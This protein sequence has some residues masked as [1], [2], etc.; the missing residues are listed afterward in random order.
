MTVWKQLG[1]V[2]RNTFN[3]DR[4]ESDLEEE[5]RAYVDL[6][7]AE[8]IQ[9][10]MSPEL[11]QR[12]ALMEVGSM[13]SVKEQVREVSAGWTLNVLWLDVHHALRAM[14]RNAGST[15][16]AILTLTLGISAT[17]TLFSVFYS[18]LLRPL[19]FREPERIVQIYESRMQRNLP[20]VTFS[21][22]NFWDLRARQRTF[23]EVAALHGG[24]ANMTGF[25]Q[26]EHVSL[27]LVSAGF[28]RVLGVRP[29]LGRDFQ[30]SED[31]PGSQNQ[32]ALLRDRFW[33]Q[34]FNADP[35]IIGRTLRLDNKS[36]IV[37]GV[38]P[39]GEPWLDAADIFVPLV[40]SPQANRGS[41]EYAVIGRLSRGVTLD[42]ARANL[43]AV[44]AGLAQQYPQDDAGMGAFLQPSNTWIADSDVR[45]ALWVLLGA[46]GLLLLIACVNVANLLL[47]RASERTREM[48]IRAALGASR[49]RIV[50]LLLTESTLLAGISG[51]GGVLL[52]IGAMAA[53]RSAHLEALPRLSEV[54]VNG[55]VLGFAVVTVLLTGI[56]SGLAP[57][58][59]MPQMNMNPAL[60]EGGRTH[61]A[62]RSQS[63]LRS[64]LVAGE[65]ALSLA[66]LVGAGLLIRSF[67]RLTGVERGF[68]SENRLLFSVNLLS[69][70]PPERVSQFIKTF[71]ER[72]TV[73]PEIKSV[74]VS[75]SRLITGGNTGMGIVA[76]DSQNA[77]GKN[78]PWAGWRVITPA[79]FE[80]LGIPLKRGRIFDE[81][82]QLGK[83]WR[84]IL[85]QRLAKLLFRDQDPIGQRVSLW[86]G[87]NPGL[88]AEVVGV[89][90]DMRER[91]LTS[92]PTLAVYIPH[93]GSGSTPLEFVVHTRSYATKIVPELRSLLA[94]IDPTLPLSEVQS[95]NEL[96]SVSLAPNRFRTVTLA[97]FAG[98]ALLLAISGIYGVLAYSISRRTSEFGLRLTLGASQR[99]ILIMTTGQGMRPV[100]AGVIVGL[101]FAWAL[102]SFM[103]SLLFGVGQFDLL[104]YATVAVLVMATALAACCVPALRATQVDPATALRAE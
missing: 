6:L 21:A 67:G 24:D 78:I 102:S 83:P 32:V 11:A 57:A 52:A 47:A 104:T 74:A 61:T 13:E 34:R 101:L 54:T 44:C 16:L 86:K 66:L 20:Q 98:L 68:Q 36:Y 28:W 58:F 42:A 69:T 59:H 41:W 35:G 73:L 17:T 14:K 2:I 81:H 50:R 89:V 92:D 48:A 5:V 63:R 25:A 15:V 51:V 30:Y 103:S 23:E 100:M 53:L 18:V 94:E 91:G 10:G 79:Y 56:L 12:Q 97:L 4:V 3:R 99:R 40:Y 93:Y 33:R 8:K 37:I 84:V 60:H 64:A 26:P 76:A 87:Q 96:V 85:S 31:Q 27:G 80:T 9:S 29:S 62:S 1:S 82:D 43:Q 45:R 7:R 77:F 22:A 95:M 90:G 72:A 46:V 49:G 39:P 88:A 19:P 70:T 55:W 75:N 65:V 71:T 38:L